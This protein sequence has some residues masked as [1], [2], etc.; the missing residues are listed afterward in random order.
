MSLLALIKKIFR[1]Q[2]PQIFLTPFQERLRRSARAIKSL[3]ARSQAKRDLAER[4]A[5]FMTR[6][7]GSITFLILNLVWFAWWIAVNLGRVPGI[8]PFDPFP[9][10]LLTMI[11]S[12]E[13]IML[14]I[15]VLISQNR[16]QK[17][18]DIREEI[19][20]EVDVIAESEVTKALELLVK[21]AKKSGVDLSRDEELSEMLKPLNRDKIE[22]AFE[23]EIL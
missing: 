5:D 18:N 23:K 22:K 8:K 19:D 7:F 14:A 15:F 10:G 13:A 12:L 21:I 16:E 17:V 9:F 4:V 11:V 6:T 20:L 2:V 3:K 1:P